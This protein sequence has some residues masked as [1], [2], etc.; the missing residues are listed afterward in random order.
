MGLY[1]SL[2]KIERTG[3]GTVLM[4]ILLQRAQKYPDTVIYFRYHDGALI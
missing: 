1:P 3:L 2:G 4:V